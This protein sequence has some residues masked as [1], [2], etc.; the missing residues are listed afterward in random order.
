MLKD[1]NKLETFITVVKEKSFSKASGKLG[2]SQPAV[3][4]QIKFIEDYLDA[5]VVDR[6]KS[7]IKLTKEGEQL[8][9]IALKL[10]KHI[11]E[12]ENEIFKIINKKMT[13]ALS[14]SFTIGNYILPNYLNDIQRHLNNDINLTVANSHQCI[15]NILDK[16]SDLALIESPIMKDGVIYRD[17]FDDELVLFSNQ[18]LPGIIKKD[19]LLNFSWICRD[20][21]SSTRKLMKEMFEEMDIDC[22]SFDV[23]SVVSSS[24]TVLRTILKSKKDEK[25][26]VSIISRHVIADD[27]EAGR[28]F[29]AK[30]RNYK[31]ERKF[32][33]AYSKERKHDPFVENVVNYLLELK[34]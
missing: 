24:T 17:W 2:V 19:D 8:L 14:S 20:E 23:K 33:I 32:Y 34:K 4:Q 25:P 26:T 15:E 1:F 3:T 6:K 21:N 11:Q 31:I 30:I 12:S 9:T 27:V 13:F 28:L 7:G 16:R 10:E 29:Q 5:K 22:T 18:P